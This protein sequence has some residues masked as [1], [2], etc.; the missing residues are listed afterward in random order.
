[1]HFDKILSGDNLSLIIIHMMRNKQIIFHKKYK[2]SICAWPD[3]ETA[4]EQ[5][6]MC[7]LT[8]FSLVIILLAN[9]SR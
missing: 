5:A 3:V 8:R 1:M 4:A 6:Q 9:R 7:V 2:N